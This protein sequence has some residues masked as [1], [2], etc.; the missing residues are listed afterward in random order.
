MVLQSFPEYSEKQNKGVEVMDNPVFRDDYG[1]QV[2]DVTLD[3]LAGRTLLLRPILDELARVW[4][5]DPSR[6]GSISFGGKVTGNLAYSI[7][8]N[9]R[10]PI[11]I[12]NIENGM[13]FGVEGANLLV[14]LD[15]KVDG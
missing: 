13:D 2:L 8:L 3:D 4:G 11:N 12:A 9:L 10:T 5:G 1:V 7:V 15:D 14:D 6:I